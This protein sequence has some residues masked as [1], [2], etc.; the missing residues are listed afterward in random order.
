[1]SVIADAPMATSL[2]PTKSVFKEAR[3]GDC[4]LVFKGCD[5]RG[6]DN[7]V[8][9][10]LDETSSDASVACR[11]LARKGARCPITCAY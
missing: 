5:M 10:H 2:V 4:M 6:R 1:M 11:G 7:A 8:H 3:G 9:A